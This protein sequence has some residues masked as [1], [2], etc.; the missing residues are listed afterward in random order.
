VATFLQAL[1]AATVSTTHRKQLKESQMFTKTPNPTTKTLKSAARRLLLVACLLAILCIPSALASPGSLDLSFGAGG[2]VTTPF[3][4]GYDSAEALAL[5]A[6]GRLV[7]AGSTFNGSNDD[8]AVARYNPNGSLDTSFNGTGRVTTAIGSAEDDAAALVLQPDG[9]LVAAGTSRLN[10]KEVFALA[11]YNPDGSLDTSFNGTGKVTTPVGAIADNVHG[12]AL[13][14][15][16]KLVAAGYSW[17]GTRNVF[18]LARYNPDGSLDTSFNGTGTV[19]TAIGSGND[20]AAAL[21]LQ[22]NGR[23]VVA[24]SSANGSNN[25]FALARYNADGSLDTSFNGTG[26]VT[27]AFGAGLAGAQALAIQPDGKLVAAG[28]YYKSVFAF[29]LARYNPDG[30]LDTSFNGTGKVTTAVGPGIFPGDFVEALALQPDGRIV[31]AGRSWNGS[32]HDLA[33]ARYNPNGALDTSFNGTGKVRTSLGSGNDGAEALVRQPDG[34]L[35]VAG[36]S[37][38]GDFALARYRVD[39]ALTVAKTGGG[40]GS[41]TSNPGGISCGSTCSTAFAAPVPVTLTATPAAGSSFLGWSGACSGTGKCSLTMSADR[42]ATARFETNKTLTLSKTGSGAGTVAS[43]PAGISCGSAC[44]RAFRHGTPITLTATPAAGSS[45]LGWSG[46]CSGTGKCSLAMSAS[47]AATARF[48]TNK[49]LALTKAGRGV[50]T[51]TSSPAGISCGS[52]CAHVFRHGTAVTLTAAASTRSTFAGWSGACSGTGSCTLTMSA[53]RSVTA[54]FKPLCVVPKLKGKTLRA[55]KKAIRRA[56]CSVGKVT[57]EFSAKVKN[58]RVISQKPK[59][60]K[61][62]AAGSKVRLK[63]SKG[64][65]A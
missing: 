9:K 40:S 46:A 18:A 33:L 22:P 44:A 36:Y 50:G 24:G 14:P 55:A 12:L 43:S 8:F 31:A 6:N 60:G 4:S 47:R 26:K 23:I 54:T 30:S 62:L 20:S 35:V 2:K 28:S 25:E 39:S 41:I 10:G 64:K 5:Q 37:S 59:P 29:A 27:T 13:Q 63:V 45:F 65:K 58:G 7:A 11:R 42:A 32:S 48:E 53:S 3:G 19:M 51:V 49:T 16:G 15:D 17:D 34:R 1:V 61:K 38:N 57:R 52:A 21:V 56:H